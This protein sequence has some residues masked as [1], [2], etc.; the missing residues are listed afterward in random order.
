MEQK[1]PM[2]TAIFQQMKAFEQ[3]APRTQLPSLDRAAGAPG[4]DEHERGIEPEVSMR[5]HLVK[6]L[7][8]PSA[9]GVGPCSRWNPGWLP[10]AQMCVKMVDLHN[11]HRILVCDL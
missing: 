8:L 6:L 4:T 10:S 9:F 11:A 5:G 7:R 3:A 1:K 2:L